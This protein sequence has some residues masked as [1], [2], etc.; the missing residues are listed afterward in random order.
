MTDSITMVLI[1]YLKELIYWKLS[2]YIELSAY[3]SMHSV[4]TYVFSIHS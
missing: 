2:I 1:Y 4:H 3:S